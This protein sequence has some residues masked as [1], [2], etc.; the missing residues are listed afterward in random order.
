MT[1]HYADPRSGDDELKQASRTCL[2]QPDMV[3][4]VL[5]ARSLSFRAMSLMFFAPAIQSTPTFGHPQDLPMYSFVHFH[6]SLRDVPQ[7][8]TIQHA[9]WSNGLI[10]P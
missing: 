7:W 9:G 1:L 8:C 6:F 10:K 5:N 4:E 2:G 3:V